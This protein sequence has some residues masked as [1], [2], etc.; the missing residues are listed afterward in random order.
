MLLR[1]GK[2]YSFTPDNLKNK[3]NKS[4]KI[5]KNHNIK[6]H[7]YNLFEHIAISMSMAIITL[8]IMNINSNFTNNT[9][10]TYCEPYMC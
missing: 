4:N 8:T 5:S 7:Y 6:Q 1:S 3:K 2:S 9:N 10:N